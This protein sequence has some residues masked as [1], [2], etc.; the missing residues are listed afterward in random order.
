MSKYVLVDGNYQLYRAAYSGKKSFSPTGVYTGGTIVFFQIL[1]GL[2]SFN[3]EIVVVFDHSRAPWRVQAYPEYKKRKPKTEAEQQEKTLLFDPSLSIVKELIPHLGIPRLIMSEQEGDD[4][5]YRLSQGLVQKGHAVMVVSDDRDYLQ[6]CKN[7]V[8]IY[9]PMKEKFWSGKGFYPNDKE[10]NPET[11]LMQ[12]CLTGDKSDNIGNPPG[13]GPVA[14]DKIISELKEYTI[15]GLVHWL[16]EEPNSKYKDKI[17]DHLH[18]VKRNWSLMNL[19]L[20]PLTIEETMLEFDQAKREAIPNYQYVYQRFLE[21][22]IQELRSWL[23][24][25]SRQQRRQHGR[26]LQEM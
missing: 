20:I 26:G 22:G 17:R 1:R 21:L 6:F 14:A 8:Q 5:L 7:G 23:G 24:F 13:I 15:P 9:Q 10:F 3:A 25:V 2:L 4:V 11:I 12:R 19:D 18:I 16:D